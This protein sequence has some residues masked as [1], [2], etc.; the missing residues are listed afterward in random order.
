MFGERLK[1][2]R[3]RAGLS[4][5][6][7]SDRMQNLV[8]AQAIGKYETGQ[9]LPSSSVLVALGD[10]LNVDLEFLTSTQVA[11]L[12]GVEFRKDAHPNAKETSRIEATIIDRV[13]RYL[14]IEAVLELPSEKHELADRK[15]QVADS[16][17]GVERIADQLR[18][19]WNLGVDP[20]PSVAKL[21]EEKGIKVLAID[22]PPSF[23]GLTCEVQRTN[24]M[25]PL[26]VVVVSTA[27]TAERRRFTLCHE[28]AHRL[29]SA[30]V[31][32]LDHE[33]AMHRFASAF[34]MP[35][36]SLREEFGDA[37]H[38]LAYAEI[39]SAKHF[40]GVSAAA[41]IVRLR[42]LNIIR[43]GYLSYLFQTMARNWRSTEP[44]PL[45]EQGEMA[46]AE[47]PERF[48]KLVYRAL[49]EQLIALPKASLLL[50]KPAHDVQIAMRGAAL[51]DANNRQ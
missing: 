1:L 23:S 48:E 38:A 7:L 21:L 16:Y 31:N 6:E 39:K 3:N 36:S 49:A 19:D 17:E 28:L 46:R 27:I 30:V 15:P 33:K 34:L 22:M 26:P 47:E 29:I 20:I 51:A 45:A 8:S 37:R 32:G 14:N 41:L 44:D 24:G 25:P 9:M 10:A 43:D 18:A 35:A 50:Q 13:E 40:Y 11:Q 4:L 42:D 12:C 2:A 5:R